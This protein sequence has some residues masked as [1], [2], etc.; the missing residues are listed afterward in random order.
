[1]QEIANALWAVATMNQQVEETQLGQMLNA[2]VA[3]LGDAEP[4]EVSNTLWACAEFRYLPKQLLTAS[5]LLDKVCADI[6]QGLA[7]TAFARGELGYRD[8]QLVSD[9][10]EQFLRL[11]S[12]GMHSVNSR[13][14]T[15]QTFTNVCWSVAVL[16]MRQHAA[17]VLTLVQ[18]VQPLW[19][20][21]VPENIRQ[22]Y[23][24]YMWLTDHNLASGQGL[25]GVL[26][27]QQMQ[28]C[29]AAWQRSA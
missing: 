18:A 20:S 23:Q 26:A 9:L 15:A 24:A 3:K 13:A 16:D 12:R 14:F 8:E 11:A 19:A 2:L 22:L 1:M 4:Q 21:M 7:S 17:A 10:L 5:G 27:A 6:P 28:Q 25:A 29:Q